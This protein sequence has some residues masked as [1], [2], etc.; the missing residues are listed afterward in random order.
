M[1]ESPGTEAWKPK[2]WLKSDRL[3]TTLVTIQA[4]VP[5]VPLGT[6]TLLN[7]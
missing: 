6:L 3:E 5:K 1:V 7:P 4:K 2:K